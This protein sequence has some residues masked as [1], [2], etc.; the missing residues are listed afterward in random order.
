MH[1]EQ[2]KTEKLIEKVASKATNGFNPYNRVHMG[3]F[4]IAIVAVAGTAGYYG[5]RTE[6]KKKEE[7]K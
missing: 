1:K 3:A 7:K 4:L 2:T 6:K 5:L